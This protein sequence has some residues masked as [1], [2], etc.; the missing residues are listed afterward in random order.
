MVSSSAPKEVRGFG[1]AWIVLAPL[2]FLAAA[3]STVKSDVTYQ[4]QLAIFS[5]IAITALACGIGAAMRHRWGYRGITALSW[6][7]TV[8]FFGSGI[9]GMVMATISKGFTST[10]LVFALIV[11]VTGVPFLLMAIHLT[12]LRIVGDA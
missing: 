11:S 6:L 9:V 5:L 3:I 1:I 8:Y 4:V 12:K 7:A 10:V 2:I